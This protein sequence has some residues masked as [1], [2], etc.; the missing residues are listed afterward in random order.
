[1]PG[2]ARRHAPGEEPARAVRAWEGLAVAVSPDRALLGPEAAALLVGALDA[3]VRVERT[4]LSPQAAH[5]RSVLALVSAQLSRAGMVIGHEDVRSEAAS[6]GSS[7]WITTAEAAA[8]LG[9]T[10]RHCSRLAAAE[11]FGVAR[12][13]GRRWLVRQNEVTAW[14][15]ERS[16]TP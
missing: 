15:V 8:Q 3:V 11:E 5:V 9:L 6:A 2:Q 13:Q 14:A 12:R 10:Q 1:M 4:R 7:V 16:T